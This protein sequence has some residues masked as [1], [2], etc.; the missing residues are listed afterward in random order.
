MTPVQRLLYYFKYT[1]QQLDFLDLSAYLGG[2]RCLTFTKSRL[3][4][5]SWGYKPCV[6]RPFDQC[7]KL[8][9][10]LLVK[11]LQTRTFRLAV[12]SLW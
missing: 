4:D 1:W 6:A 2:N 12:L 10:T 8:G 3:P 7:P 9:L 11:S 5:S